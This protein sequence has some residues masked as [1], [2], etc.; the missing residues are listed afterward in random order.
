MAKVAVVLA[1][2]GVYDGSEIHEATLTLLSLDERG[3]EV[4]CFAPDAE[5][6]HV[7]D[8]T[9]GEATEESRNVMV[10][11]SRISRG[12]IQPLSE[13]TAEFDALILPGGYG[14]AK[15]LSDF[16]VNGAGCV[17]I[18]DLERAILEFHKRGKPIGFE[19]IAP[20][21]GAKVFGTADIPVRLTIGHDKE[22]AEAIEAMGATHVTCDVDEIVTDEGHKIVSTPAYMLGPGIADVAKGI[23]KLVDK[24][25]SLV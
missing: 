4:T 15:N 9:R 19:C 3:A 18:P 24:V 10:E 13:L 23:H 1:G 12:K 16:A 6:M 5:Q 21:I 22:T 8:H 25:L 20:V 14:A 7:I 17:V 2:C 11:A